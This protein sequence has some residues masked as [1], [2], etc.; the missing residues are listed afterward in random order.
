MRELNLVC[1]FQ[2]LR[3]EKSAGAEE[4]RGTKADRTFQR[5]KDQLR[6]S[7]Q[8]RNINTEGFRIITIPSCR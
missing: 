7:Q 8:T 4:K 5:S 6:I 1:Q 2:L 3:V